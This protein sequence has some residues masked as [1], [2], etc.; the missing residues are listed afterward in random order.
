M[1]LHQL[2]YLRAVVRSGSVTAAAAAEHVA[3]PSVSKQIQLLERELGVVLLHRVGRRALPTDAALELADCADRVLDDLASTIAALAGPDSGIGGSVRVCATETVVNFLLPSVLRQL[4]RELPS[5]SVRVEMLGA[6]EVV[7][8]VLADSMD[9]GLL[10]LPLAD[11]RLEIQSLLAE[12]IL[13]VV[14]LD[15]AWA[16]RAAVDLGEVLRAPDLLLSMPGMGLRSQIDAAAAA[17]GLEVH[18]PIELRSQQALLALV[19]AGAGVALAPRMSVVA[20][21]DVRLLALDPPLRREIVWIRRRGRHISA[22][23]RRLIDLL[24]GV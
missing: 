6:P 11:S 24:R 17:L 23:G 2:R 1:E 21:H 19:A 20:R 4:R 7:T 22:A 10:P 3:Q 16:D 5:A 14:P 8:Q 12:D 9:F 15:H 13:A 18:S